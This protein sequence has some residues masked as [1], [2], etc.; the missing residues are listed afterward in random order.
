MAIARYIVRYSQQYS[1][2]PKQDYHFVWAL[3]NTKIVNKT[4]NQTMEANNTNKAIL[5][6]LTYVIISIL[7]YVSISQ[8]YIEL[9]SN[10]VNNNQLIN[11]ILDFVKVPLNSLAGLSRESIIAHILYTNIVG[12][13]TIASAISI[14][15]GFRDDKD[16]N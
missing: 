3:G 8:E 7:F 13:Y 11:S 16:I 6:S 9:I 2:V 5:I 1:L 12:T 10:Y 14:F 15:E 4:D